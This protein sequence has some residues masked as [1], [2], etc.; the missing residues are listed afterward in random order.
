MHIS[1]CNN[2]DDMRSLAKKKLPKP[3]FHYI[4]GGA[5]DEVTYKNN[6]T[7]FNNYE[8]IPNVLKNV[9]NINT[10]V[11]VLGVNINI[12]FFCSPTAL[13][14]L[15]HYNG[16][17]AV[18]KAAEKENT[19]FGV[20]SLST[21]SVEEIAKIIKSP[22]LFQLYYH[23]D[24]GLNN[25][26]IERAKEAKFDALALTVDTIVGGNR[27]RDLKTGFTIPPKLSF[28]S[29]LSFIFHPEWTLNFLLRK[30]DLPHLSKFH[31]KGSS[32]QVSVS[33]YFT[34]MIDQTMSW[35]DAE[36]ISNKWNGPFCLKGIISAEDARKAVD[37]GAT[38][39]MISN[40]GGRQLDGSV[41]PIDQLS[42]IVDAVGGKI[43]IILDGGVR[44]GTHILKALSLGATA[45]SGGRLYLYA[46]A[47]S[48]QIGV[49]K[50]LSNLRNEIERD[51]KLM[52]VTSVSELNSRM[53]RKKI[54]NYKVF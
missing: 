3:V 9:S 47:A 43:E 54:A 37:I 1:D 13:Q 48:G 10:K 34:E 53:I 5:D 14:K 11:N 36:N 30:F 31:N 35:K 2:V 38:A 20:S 19:M 15:F 27:E 12:P 23:K 4:D 8:L 29:F 49:E 39:I 7:A 26:M 51:M 41:A 16:E 50:A 32:F 17:M 42:E 46:L 22:K 33:Q 24:R 44:R 28:N 45:C 52:G 6:T 25:D 21:T 40:H 18:A